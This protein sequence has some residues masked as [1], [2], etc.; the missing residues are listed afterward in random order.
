MESI[1]AEQSQKKRSALIS[2]K[3]SAE[4]PQNH[5]LGLFHQGLSQTVSNFQELT[6]LNNGIL[7]VGLVF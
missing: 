5:G 3:F 2:Q 1:V 6:T 4:V 7:L